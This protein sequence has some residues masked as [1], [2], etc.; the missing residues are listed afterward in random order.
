MTAT[1][2]WDK[3]KSKVQLREVYGVSLQ[4]TWEGKSVAVQNVFFHLC[5]F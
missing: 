2:Y 5:V 3:Y 4:E 1:L